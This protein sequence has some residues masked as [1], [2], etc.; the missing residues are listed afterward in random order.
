MFGWLLLFGLGFAVVA[1]GDDKPPREGIAG[2][3]PEPDL[4]GYGKLEQNQAYELIVAS[5]FDEGIE[6]PTHAQIQALIEKLQAAFNKARESREAADAFVENLGEKAQAMLALLES[7]M[8]NLPQDG[9]MD[10]GTTAV[11]RTLV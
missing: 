6:D 11:V 9:G 7:S 8:K 2:D 3:G 1:G 10:G 5:G 4:T